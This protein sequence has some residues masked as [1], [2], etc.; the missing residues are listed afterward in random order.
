MKNGCW[1][2]DNNSISEEE[3]IAELVEAVQDLGYWCQVAK[4]V[5]PESQFTLVEEACEY[6]DN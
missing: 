1:F 5:L 3:A 6:N 2:L 4:D